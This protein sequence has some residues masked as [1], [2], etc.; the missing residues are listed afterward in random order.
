[1]QPPPRAESR[2]GV[3]TV[4]VLG[5]C[6]H[7]TGAELVTVEARFDPRDRERTEVILTGLP[8]PVLRESR[9]R[10]ECA[11]SENGLRLASGRL[12]LNLVPAA[13]RKSGEILDLPL[14]LGAAAASGHFDPKA[15]RG[16]LFLG[17]MG[18]DGTLHAV[19]GGLA[20][21]MAARE[22]GV[23]R[24]IA[25]RETAAEA[26]CLVGME[27]FGAKH[28]AAVV[29]H[30]TGNGP[31]LE[32]LAAPAETLGPDDS[33]PSLDDVRG[34]A[35]AKH[36]L[37]VAAAG[38][39]GLLLVGP[40]GAGKSMLA[41]RLGRL[42]PP[43]S[44]EERLEI[45]RVLSAAGRW[46]GGLARSRPCRA[47][48]HTV[49]YAG[50]VGGGVHASPGEIT[51]AHCGVLFLDELPEFRREALEA[52][53]QPLESGFVLIS[54]AAHQVELP[55]RFRLVAAMNPCPCGYRGHPRI[56]CRCPPAWVQRYRQRISGPLF[57]RI[58]LVVEVAAPAL[59]ELTRADGHAGGN[60]GEVRES[61]LRAQVERAGALSHDRQGSKRN[62][63]LTAD[64]LDRFVPIEKDA[65]SLLSAAARRRGFSARAIQSLRR[66]A[67]T[68]ADMEGSPAVEAA[69]LAQ[70][71][72]L[73]AEIG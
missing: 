33:V 23:M 48:H 32:R 44:L 10:L 15:L 72:A 52:L 62:S 45:T 25:P 4:R 58:D 69:H 37:A 31:G 66:V 70:A 22:K 50:L 47:P 38:G 54:R 7:G 17:E 39:H 36:A 29:A 63:D 6:L 8:D 53:R 18:I 51:L 73:R 68:V 67:R 9:G 1:M 30:L 2:P 56:P 61:E 57:D 40:P 20:A 14:A 55:A 43:P 5:A 65:R 46:P 49:S 24:V 27:A 41:R 13:R 42:L 21:A 16:T 34:L 11:L 64:E 12:Y 19:P 26:A 60:A 28:L 3:K 59:E 35:F 71:I